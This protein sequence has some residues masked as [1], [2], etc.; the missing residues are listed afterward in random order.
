MNIKHILLLLSSITF[1]FASDNQNILNSA[2]NS[3][4]FSISA[5]IGDAEGSGTSTSLTYKPFDLN[6]IFQYSLANVDI[7]EIIGL[8]VYGVDAESDSLQL[9]Y[10]IEGEDNSHII[11]FIS[12]GS[13]EYSFLGYGIEADST[14]FGFLYR[15]LASEKS[16]LTFGVAYVDYDDVSI[17]SSTRTAINNELT[18]AGYGTYSSSEFDAIESDSSSSNTLFTLN[19]EIHFTENLM[20]RY[21]L[22][23]DFDTSTFSLGGGFKF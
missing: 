1:A 8:S 2:Y 13:L 5:A 17:P 3:V 7:D 16:V 11:P 4:D 15:A 14:T 10:L 23:T 12:M 20:M 22:A 9:G 6:F 19:L 21:G 18:S